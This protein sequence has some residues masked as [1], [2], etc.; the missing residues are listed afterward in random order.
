MDA[1]RTLTAAGGL[2]LAVALA[3][4]GDDPSPAVE[5]ASQAEFDATGP[6]GVASFDVTFVDRSRSTR[7]NGTFPGAPE[8]TLV[9]TVWYPIDGPASE[10]APASPAPG[11]F[12]L[13]GYAHGF[14]SGRAAGGR[15]GEHLASH[16][17][18]VV[19]PDFPLSNGGAPGGPTAGDLAH[20]PADLGFVMRELA[21][22][23]HPVADAID[24]TRQGIAGLSLG[25]ATVVTAAYHPSLGLDFIDAAVALAPAACF[26]GPDFYANAVPTMLIAGTADELVPFDESPERAFG[27]APS[28]TTL[29]RLEGDTHVGMLGIDAPGAENSDVLVGCAAVANEVGEEDE[30]SFSGSE[31]LF[32]RGLSGDVYRADGCDLER[33]CNNGY[34]QTMSAQRQLQLVRIATLAHFEANLRG[35]ADA[36]AFLAR[37]LGPNNPDAAVQTK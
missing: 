30:S 8:R 26:T 20:Q 11:S 1:L 34:V 6:Y 27:W 13:I 14:T 25:G 9:S 33:F 19:A 2:A 4:C 5:P 16:G 12:P 37:A 22:L 17:Y 24:T 15:L 32:T 36:A 35:R 10:G 23:D 29:L 18:V 7:A 28:P 31:D 3:G 21:A